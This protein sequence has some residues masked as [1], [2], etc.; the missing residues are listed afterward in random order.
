MEQWGFYF[1]QT[2]CIGCKACAMA[3]KNWNDDKRGDK[4]VHAFTFNDKD[5]WWENNKYSVGID[6][7][8]S[9]TFY[10]NSKGETNLSE[11]RKYYMKENWRRVFNYEYGVHWP[12]LKVNHLSMACNHCNNPACAAICPVN[13]INKE[14]EFGIVLVNS[15]VCISCGQC[16]LSCPWGVPQYYDSNFLNYAFDD[17][18]RPRMTKCT[19]CLDRIKEG[20]KPACVAACLNRALDAGPVSELRALY[21]DAVIITEMPVNEFAPDI[22]S[23][24]RTGPNVLVKVK[25]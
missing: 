7:L 15:Q 22:F 3:C 6:N 2:R 12:D 17:P 25:E 5:G 19:F 20:L 9:A 10:L 1:D 23:G 21:K 18:T 11:A 13:A 4:L 16:Q 8:D 14:P 24:G